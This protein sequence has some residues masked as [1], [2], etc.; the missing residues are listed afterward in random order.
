MA[1]RE[2]SFVS[3]GLRFVKS[4]HFIIHWFVLDPPCH[5]IKLRA[6]RQ[7][8]CLPYRFISISVL[9]KDIH[10]AKDSRGRGSRRNAGTLPKGPL[11][12]PDDAAPYN[13][14]NFWSPFW[15]I[16]AA[17]RVLPGLAAD[18]SLN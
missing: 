2:G 15:T 7:A 12:T 5:G 9:F 16:P 14:G 18:S 6:R 4:F 11:I 13:F 3:R 17:L 10:P 1:P 8:V